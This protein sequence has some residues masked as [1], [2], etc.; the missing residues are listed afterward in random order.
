MKT[1]G[2]V[3]RAGV[4]EGVALAVFAGMV[5]F[6]VNKIVPLIAG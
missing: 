3:S 4:Y 5:V 1:M 6:F 2:I